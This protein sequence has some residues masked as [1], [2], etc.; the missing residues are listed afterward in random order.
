MSRFTKAVLPSL[1]GAA[2]LLGLAV[3]PQMAA[4]QTRTLSNGKQLGLGLHLYCADFDDIL[5]WP[6]S[7]ITM[8][9]VTYP[10]IKN[11]SI[12]TTYNPAKSQFLFNSALGGVSMNSVQDPVGTPLYYE[13]KPWPDGRRIVVY[14]DGHA[15]IE[16][17]DAWATISKKLKGKWKR[18]AAKPL[19]KNHGKDMFR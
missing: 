11:K 1:V 12:W 9:G 17:A 3:V 6:Q 5:P 13:S 19:P 15:R 8:K 10:Y 14:V 18:A 4:D 16:S 2:T 7:I